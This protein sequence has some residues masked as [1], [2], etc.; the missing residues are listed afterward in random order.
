MHFK[1]YARHNWRTF[2]RQPLAEISGAVGDLGTFL[3]ILIVLSVNHTISLPSTLIFS[4]VWNIITGLFFGIPLP[5]QPMKAIAAVAI[6]GTY[7]PGEIAAAGLF[8]AACILL[9]SVTGLLH[10]FSR[11]VPIPVIKGIQVGAGLSLIISAGR[12]M[13]GSLD[14]LHPSWA[15]NYIWM[16]A[17]ALGLILTTVY[18]RVPYGLMLVVLGLVLAIVRLA[19]SNHAHAPSFGIWYPPIII[20][21]PREWR[22]GILDA[23]IGQVP[24]TVLNSVIAVVHLAADLLPD[25]ETP[26]VT[27]IGLSVTAMNAVGVWFGCM[28]LCH[29]SGGLAAQYRFGARSGGSIIFLG[30]VKVVIG[31]LFGNTLVDLLVKFPASILGVMVIGAG[32]ELASVGE[33]LNTAGAWDLGGQRG[34]QSARSLSGAVAGLSLGEKERK[35]RWT[36]MLVTVGFLVG[37]VNAGIGF[38]A[39]M[40]CFWAYQLPDLIERLRRRCSRGRITLPDGNS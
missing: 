15:D 5:V 40:L 35:K 39:G 26:T 2:R 8:V 37:F 22:S 30:L 21:G 19:T 28:P 18:R 34:E 29:G 36:I 38:V 7:S 10:W 32:L 17:A 14:W 33:S 20:P 6:A 16:I 13:H 27:A 24:L 23:G 1:H 31:L 9:F 25:V 4:G 12:T 11:M 3:P